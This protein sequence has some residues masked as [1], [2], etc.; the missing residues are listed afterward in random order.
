[1][2]RVRRVERLNPSGVMDEYLLSSSGDGRRRVVGL[3]KRGV[4]RLLVWLWLWLARRRGR[5]FLRTFPSASPSFLDRFVAGIR[6]RTE[7]SLEG[8]AVLTLGRR[9]ARRVTRVFTLRAEMSALS[10]LRGHHRFARHRWRSLSERR[11]LF[12]STRGEEIYTWKLR[13]DVWRGWFLLQWAQ[14][15]VLPPQ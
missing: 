6:A 14:G 13:P 3:H 12:G 5:V 9:G 7:N 15:P 4:S 10:R 8:L 11:G 2:A 1:M